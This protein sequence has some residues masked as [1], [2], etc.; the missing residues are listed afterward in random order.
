VPY[1]C[2]VVVTEFKEKEDIIVI[3]A[4]IMVERA[5]Q[6]AIII[7]HQGEAIKKVGTQARRIWKHFLEKKYFWSNT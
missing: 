4:E 2:E 6:R 5:T 3:R 1:S 7:G